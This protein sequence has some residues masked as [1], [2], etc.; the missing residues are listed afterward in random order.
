MPRAGGEIMISKEIEK[1][2]LLIAFFLTFCAILMNIVWDIINEPHEAPHVFY[3][4]IMGVIATGFAYIHSKR[5][6]G[7]IKTNVLFFATTIISFL[8]EH[9]GVETGAIYGQYHYGT[10]YGPKLFDTVPIIIPLSWFLFLYPAVIISNEILSGSKSLVSFIQK[11]GGAVQIIVFAAFDSIVMTALDILIDPI[12]TTRGSWF[13]TGLDALRPEEIFYKIPVQNYFGWL[14]TTF[15]IFAVYRTVF[16]LKKNTYEEKDKL[17][18]LPIYNY[19]GIFVI[20]TIEAWIVI[21]SPGIIFVSIM[22][23]GLISI[24]ALY[25]NYLFYK[26]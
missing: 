1:K 22:T 21:K 9:F 2:I 13:W 23:L 19:V 12:C 24:M 15:L 3:N 7:L 8:M 4:M 14:V 20:G 11:G 16:F 17:Y 25:K 26:K 5:Y 6:F 10:I 18:F